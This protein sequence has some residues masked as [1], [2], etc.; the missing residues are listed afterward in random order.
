MTSLSRR[1]FRQH[2]RQDTP[3][4]PCA[5][6]MPFLLMIQSTHKFSLSIYRLTEGLGRMTE[7]DAHI[8]LGVTS[9]VNQ[10]DKMR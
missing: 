2:P 10:G 7:R 1:T 6:K 4:P 3:E 5:Y 8:C 9:R